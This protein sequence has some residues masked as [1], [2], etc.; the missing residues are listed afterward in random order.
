MES[1]PPFW[2]I[3]MH[4]MKQRKG[5]YSKMEYNTVKMHHIYSMYHSYSNDAL[6]GRLNHQDRI[7]S[8]TFIYPCHVV[9]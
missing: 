3:H 8:S 6:L 5:N 1:P 2:V 9:N 7:N 4:L